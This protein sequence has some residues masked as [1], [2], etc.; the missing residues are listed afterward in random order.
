MG[1]DTSF[2]MLRFNVD[3]RIGIAYNWSNYFVGL[4]SQ[5]KNFNFKKDQCKVN[6]YDA[7]AR[8]SFGVRL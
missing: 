2:S 7:W 4:Q 5:F 1:S 6:L 8:L 3:L